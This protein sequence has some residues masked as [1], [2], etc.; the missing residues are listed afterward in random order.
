MLAANNNIGIILWA[1]VDMKS[2]L[3]SR[4]VIASQ[5]NIDRAVYLIYL[6]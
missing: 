2:N 1:D 6:Q 4:R 5:S 3:L